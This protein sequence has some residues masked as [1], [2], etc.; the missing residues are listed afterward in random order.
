MS[1]A[2]PA[3]VTRLID[4]FSRLPGIGPKT[5]ARLT[6][7]LLRAPEEQSLALSEALRELKANTR[8][9]SVCY[10]ITET[11]PCEI[12]ADD[13]RDAGLIC[14][15]EE[16]LDVIAIDR[17][18]NYNGRFHVLHGA[19][20][21]MEGIGP[22]NLRIQELISR[23]ENTPVREVILATNV[24]LEGDATAMYIHQRLR[25]KVRLTRLARGLPVGGDLE[26]ADSVTLAGALEGR[27]EMDA[28]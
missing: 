14:V 28:G 1:K 16:P 27:R 4:E 5:A 6:Y 15:V 2:I 7:Y 25:G 17:A 21:P 12:C 19:I 26:Y 3:S 13:S 10:N 23:V 8:F 11:D 20:N 22:E 24:G 9:C 18:A